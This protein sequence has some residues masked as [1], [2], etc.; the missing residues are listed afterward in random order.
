M[1]REEE[2][3]VESQTRV[4]LFELFFVL[5]HKLRLS[6]HLFCLRCVLSIFV[7]GKVWNN[8]ILSLCASLKIKFSISGKT[9]VN[10]TLV[11]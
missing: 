7:S 2:S 5:I 6:C 3:V 8:K 4:Y 10:L 11:F 1:T 9:S